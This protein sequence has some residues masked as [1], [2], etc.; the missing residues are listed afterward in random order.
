MIDPKMGPRELRAM[1]DPHIF[2]NEDGVEMLRSSGFAEV[3]G[4]IKMMREYTNMDAARAQAYL[5]TSLGGQAADI[6][7][8]LRL[9]RGGSGVK[10]AQ[11]RLRDNM[12]MLLKGR[13]TTSRIK[14]LVSST[15]GNVPV[16][17]VSLMHNV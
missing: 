1:L 4:A 13:L 16:V 7:E 10:F 6:S 12:Q 11:E 8:G 17:L 2:T 3:L 9:N 5:V 14:R 15:C